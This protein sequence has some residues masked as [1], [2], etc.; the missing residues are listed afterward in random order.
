M[1]CA[2][3]FVFL[4]GIIYFRQELLLCFGKGVGVLAW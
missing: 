1:L 4:A 3:F 2:S